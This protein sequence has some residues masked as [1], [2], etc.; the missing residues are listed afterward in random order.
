[1]MQLT[2]A[3]L[4][5]L[6]N[7]VS[8][9]KCAGNSYYCVG[10]KCTAFTPLAG[11]NDACTGTSQTPTTTSPTGNVVSSYLQAVHYA[12]VGCSGQVLGV[13]SYPMYSCQQI[14]SNVNGKPLFR[15]YSYTLGANGAYTIYDETFQQNTVVVGGLPYTSNCG[16][17]VSS[18]IVATTN[19]VPALAALNN[20]CVPTSSLP[21][22]YLGLGRT[23]YASGV[24]SVQFGVSNDPS[25]DVLG[26]N[27]F[28]GNY[29][30]WAVYNTFDLTSAG[31]FNPYYASN[32]ALSVVC[33]YS[34]QTY[35]L[36][37]LADALHAVELDA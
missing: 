17:R 18:Q 21:A 37:Q 29:R 27:G 6:A 32:L 20:L 36:A 4:L 16:T 30:L 2:I 26:Q 25:N 1:M 11:A 10:P 31:T 14:S 23:P 35:P 7:A 5:V 3:L 19:N 12:A 13:A 33:A 34:Y 28:P 22:S 24:L 9:Q 8:A 15:M